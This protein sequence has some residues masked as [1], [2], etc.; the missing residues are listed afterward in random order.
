MDP[1]EI[2]VKL[3]LSD[4]AEF[5]RRLESI[6]L[7]CVQPASQ[8]VNLRFDQA[9]GVLS[10]RHQ[11]LRLRKEGGRNTLTYKGHLLNSGPIAVREEIETDV[12]DFQSMQRILECLGYEII[13]VYEKIRAVYRLKDVLLMVDHTPIGDFLEIEGPDEAAIRSAS[14][15]LNMDW[16]SGTDKSYTVLFQEWAASSHY[17]GRDMLFS[18]IEAF[19]KAS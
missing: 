17:P 7:E 1:L 2:E 18:A 3:P 10:R 16:E 6:G 4:A 8:E 12:T 11:V 14:D 13:F 19:R 15:L 5:Q 9:D